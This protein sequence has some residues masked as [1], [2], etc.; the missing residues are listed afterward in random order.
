[1]D[2]DEIANKF[3]EAINRH[4]VG[5][6]CRLMTE[7]HAFIDSGGD[8][9]SGIEQMQRAWK[10]YFKMFPDYM[11]E[12]P[13]FVVSGDTIILLGKASGTYTTDG[14]LRQK[15]HWQIP[16]AWKAVIANDKIK[17]WQVFADNTQVAEIIE[18]ESD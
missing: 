13:E 1:M 3:I 4:D 5:A 11:I 17:L 16:A 2:I 8:V 15:N 14:K 9:Y 18:K 12:A 6:I 7:D 10:E